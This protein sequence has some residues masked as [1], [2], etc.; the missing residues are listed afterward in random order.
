MNFQWLKWERIL[1][2]GWGVPL[3]NGQYVGSVLRCLRKSYESQAYRAHSWTDRR[4]TTME[5]DVANRTIAIRRKGLTARRMTVIVNRYQTPLMPPSGCIPAD[6]WGAGISSPPSIPLA[7]G[8]RLKR[9]WSSASAGGV[10]GWSISTTGSNRCGAVLVCRERPMG[11]KQNVDRGLLLRRYPSGKEVW[12]IRFT[13]NELGKPARDIKLVGGTTKEHA[14]RKLRRLLVARDT[15]ALTLRA[16]HAETIAGA[17]ERYRP[18]AMR[19]RNYRKSQCFFQWWGAHY[20]TIALAAL[21]PTHLEQAQHRLLGEGKSPATVN[22]YMDWLRH[23]LNREVRL[24][25]IPK[26]P[27]PLV[28]RLREPDAPIYQYSA[29]Q[30]QQLMA[31][32]GLK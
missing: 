6:L 8:R 15:G 7:S 24:G 14:K 13:V 3:R 27:A 30:E 29:G 19:L 12:Y 10:R 16:T 28:T 17:L 18:L 26:N 21:A 9:G 11:R 31:A 1:A 20:G 32:L 22:R 4:T 23:V 25:H 2:L 5:H